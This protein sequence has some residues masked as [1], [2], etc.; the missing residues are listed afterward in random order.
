[1][2]I[3]FIKKLS[4]YS[5]PSPEELERTRRSEPD[6]LQDERELFGYRAVSQNYWNVHGPRLSISNTALQCTQLS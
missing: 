3:D 6:F 2:S 1:M 5:Y 4:G